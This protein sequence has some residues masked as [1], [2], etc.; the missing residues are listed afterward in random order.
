MWWFRKREKIHF[1]YTHDIHS[2]VLPG[3]DDG[4]RTYGEAIMV[5]K[6]LSR[7]GVKRVTCTS[8]VYFPALMNGRENLHPLLEDLRAG[9]QK[10]GV[11][12]ELDLGAEYR[13]GEYM[14]S[15]IERGEILSGEDGTVYTPEMVLGPARRGIKMTYCTDTRPTESIVAAAEGS[16]LFICEGM[17]AEPEKLVKAKQ[18]KHMTFYE[19]ADMAKRAGVR[20]MWL[21]HYSPSLVHAENYLP[22]VREIFPDA[23]L[24]KDGKNVEL[25]FEDED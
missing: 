7:L 15:L 4:V 18:Y 8:H 20:E 14:L 11:E 2:H 12:I 19:A 9:L 1:D 24:G 25:M 6:G 23:F 22:Q 17:Y 5:L 3:V 10:E 16:D 13:V 21:T